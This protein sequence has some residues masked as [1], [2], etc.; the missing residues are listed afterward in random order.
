MKRAHHRLTSFASRCPAAGF[1]LIELLVALAVFALVV[2][3]LLNLGGESVRNAA[4][5]ERKVLA[6]I[7]ADN[8]ATEAMLA[9]AAQ[10][11]A[12]AQ[13]HENLGE[14]EWRWQRSSRTVAGGLLRIDIEVFDDD[15]AAVASAEAYR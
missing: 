13:G 11:A 10:L 12:P 6:N 5:L 14:R 4:Q 1:S 7:I 8:L 3:A 2:V 15:G 9:D